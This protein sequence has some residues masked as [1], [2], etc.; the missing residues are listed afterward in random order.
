MGWRVNWYECP[1]DINPIK[2]IQSDDGEIVDFEILGKE[3]L[4]NEGTSI[5]KIIRNR[6][7]FN[8]EIN[9]L[10]PSEDFDI[11]SIS[12]EGLRLIIL[13]Y[14]K[15]IT[16][17]FEEIYQTKDQFDMEHYF[18]KKVFEWSR[19][20]AIIENLEKDYFTVTRS[21]LFEYTIFNLVN[22]YKL[23]DWDNKQLVI[24]GG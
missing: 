15:V 10:L 2:L 4:G 8:K 13:E 17:H 5:W 24:Y 20:W 22:L 9:C 23:F 3:I 11:Y 6:E 21:S 7:D 14:K 18:R 12:K 1:K 16:E 19:G